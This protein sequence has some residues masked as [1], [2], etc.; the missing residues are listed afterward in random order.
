[1]GLKRNQPARKAYYH[2]RWATNQR[3]LNV[4]TL[5]M[6]SEN[7][8]ICFEPLAGKGNYYEYF[9]PY[10]NDGRNNYPRGKYFGPDTRA[11]ATWLKAQK[12]YSYKSIRNSWALPRQKLL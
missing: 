1:M 8:K 2:R 11:S 5:S 9:M 4:Q 12:I 7:A 10:K 3:I 6:K